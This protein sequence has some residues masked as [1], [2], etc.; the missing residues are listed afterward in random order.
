MDIKYVLTLVAGVLF[1]LGFVPYIRAIVRGETKP[2]KASWMI[3]ASLDTITIIGMY[4]KHAVNGQIVGA[5]LGAWAVVVLALIYGLPGW[6]KLDKQCLGG[7]VLGIVLWLVF[8]EA[9]FGIVVSNIVVFL[10]AIPTFKSAW[11]DPS[12]EDKIAW[13]I[14]WLSCVAAIFAIPAL[15]F[16]DATQP[17]VFFVIET[18]MMYILYIRARVF[19]HT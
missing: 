2:A 6:T 1:I 11:N 5:V 12:K 18:V 3:W 14:F 13:T 7:A 8:G 10:G 15:T 16:E 4:F 19:A 9:N 17:V